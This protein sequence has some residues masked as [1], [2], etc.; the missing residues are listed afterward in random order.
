M[1]LI[2]IVLAL[3]TSLTVSFFLK[4]QH[5]DSRLAGT[6]WICS[7]SKS[8]FLRASFNE[9]LAIDETHTLFFTS[10]NMMTQYHSGDVYLRS[11]AQRSFEVAYTVNYKLSDSEL[12]MVYEKIMWAIKPNDV[13]VFVN[14]ID[15][16]EGFSIDVNYYVDGQYLYLFNKSESEDS[17]FVCHS[18]EPLLTRTGQK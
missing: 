8:H 6:R 11:G 5:D 10:G 13:G 16:L 15:R 7:E 4:T 9:Y 12:K 2:T 14:H 18:S 1:Q 3:V 17:N